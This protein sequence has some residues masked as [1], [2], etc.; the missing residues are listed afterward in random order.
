MRALVYQLL[1]FTLLLS[2]ASEIPARGQEQVWSPEK[3]RLGLLKPASG[4]LHGKLRD[5]KGRVVGRMEDFL[6]DLSKS[7]VLVTLVGAS[8]SGQV[9]PVPPRDYTYIAQAR[10]ALDLHKA[11][12]EQAPQ[13]ASVALFSAVEFLNLSNSFYYFGEPAPELAATNMIVSASILMGTAVVSQENQ[14]LGQVRDV[15]LDLPTGQAVYLV[16]APPQGVAQTGSLYAVPLVLASWAAGD[17][18]LKLD[19]TREHFLAGPRFSDKFWSDLAFP[20]LASRLRSYYGLERDTPTGRQGP[21]Q[22]DQEITRAI[23]AELTQQ[24]E[25][26]STTRLAVSTLH[27]RVTLK[28]QVTSPAEKEAIRGAAER[29]VGSARVEDRLATTK[30]PA[31]LTEGLGAFSPLPGERG[32]GEGSLS[33]EH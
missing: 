33:I 28:G 20:E 3:A 4:L 26:L 18:V 19:T 8:R 14:P 7:E 24:K 23:L 17:P 27:G 32:S 22:A 6:L 11:K 2:L 13:I 15:M 9:T 25:A 30:K 16:I 31:T 10:L 21:S 12:F 1:G 5:C 29:V